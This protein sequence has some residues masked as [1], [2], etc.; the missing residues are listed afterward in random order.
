VARLLSIRLLHFVSAIFSSPILLISPLIR[1]IGGY[2]HFGKRSPISCTKIPRFPLLYF[3]MLFFIRVTSINLALLGIGREHIV[4]LRDPMGSFGDLPAG[5]QIYGI[6]WGYAYK[7]F[8]FLL[9]V[10]CR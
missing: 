3:Q 7:G 2:H 5:F 10:L 4:M 6:D 9:G 8:F 1:L